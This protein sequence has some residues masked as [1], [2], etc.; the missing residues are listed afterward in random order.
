[1]K[2][3]SPIVAYPNHHFESDGL[4]FRLL[5]G[6]PSFKWK[7]GVSVMEPQ[8]GDHQCII[9]NAIHHA[10]LICYSA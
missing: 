7:L 9:F 8:L 2:A 5:Q 3:M 4:P 10:V 1:M 6:K